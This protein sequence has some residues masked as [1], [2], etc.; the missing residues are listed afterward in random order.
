MEPLKIKLVTLG[1]LKYPINFAAIERWRSQVFTAKHV[2]TVQEIEDADIDHWVYSDNSLM[3]F[4]KP[5]PNFNITVGLINAPLEGNFY[6]RR[7]DNNICILSLHEIADILKLSNLKIESFIL[8]IIYELCC[9][10]IEEGKKLSAS[11]FYSVAHDET[12]GCLFDMNMNK[13]DII[14]S[15]V[16]PRICDSCRTRI[17]RS[18]VPKDF[19]PSVENELR[20]IKKDLYY[21][22]A[23]F[24]KRHPIYSIFITLLSG[25]VLNI[26]ASYLYDVLIK[27]LL[28]IGIKN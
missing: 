23:D 2:D 13:A 21:R 1:N 24:I 26:V 10:Y 17:V 12:R 15:T 8:R 4:I 27:P 25:I 28:G 5:D 14:Y 18:Q 16:R 7:L 19:L 3:R 11:S 9:L 22:L 6:L 20:E